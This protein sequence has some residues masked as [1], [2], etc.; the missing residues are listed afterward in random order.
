LEVLEVGGFV[1]YIVALDDMEEGW[2]RR[3]VF[4]SFALQYLFGSEGGEI[5]WGES[6]VLG[7]PLP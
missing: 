7:Q 4:L 2:M 5:R 3:I 6:A 1:C